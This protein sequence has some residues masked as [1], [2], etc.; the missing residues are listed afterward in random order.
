MTRRL[1]NLLTICSALLC[2][3]VAVLWVR[4]YFASDR[5]LWCPLTQSPQGFVSGEYMLATWRGALGIG[6]IRHQHDKT[7]TPAHLY[8]AYLA[9]HVKMKAAGQGWTS[10]EPDDLSLSR[11]GFSGWTVNESDPGH[12]GTGVGWSTPYWFLLLLCSLPPGLRAYLFL[13]RRRQHR[14][15]L[16]RRCGYDLRATP[17]RCPECGAGAGGLLT[18]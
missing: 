5:L 1:L 10:R 3:A 2:L 7:G 16:C 8:D 18:R 15:G 12:R 13:R 6:A 17:D 9:A 14:L 4:S 11:W